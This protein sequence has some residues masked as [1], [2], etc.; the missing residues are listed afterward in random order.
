MCPSWKER[1][2]VKKGSTLGKDPC[3]PFYKTRGG[4]YI[5]VTASQGR[6]KEREGALGQKG[7]RGK[8]CPMAR[9]PMSL[10]PA[11]CMMACVPFHASGPGNECF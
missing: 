7:V 3:S 6:E 10:V 11:Y 5:D 4:G 1:E 9:V 2:K 8:F